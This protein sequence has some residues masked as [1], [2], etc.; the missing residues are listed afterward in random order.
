MAALSTLR[1]SLQNSLGFGTVSAAQANKLDRCINS[2]ILQVVKESPDDSFLDEVINTSILQVVNDSPDDSFLDEIINSAVLQLVNESPDDSFLD[3][4]INT[5]ILQTVN[6]SPNDSQLDEVINSAILQVVNESPDDSFLDEVINS[7]ILQTVNESP[8]D[9]YLDEI[10]N[11]AV[12]QV[13]NESPDDSYLDEIINSAVLQLVNE[14]PDDSYLD[15]IINTSILQTVNESP[16]DSYLDEIIN[17]AVLQLVNES[18]DD[19]YLDEIINTAI[20][21]VVNESLDNDTLDEALNAGLARAYSDGIPGIERDVFMGETSADTTMRLDNGVDGTTDNQIGDTSIA[22]DNGSGVGVLITG[23]VALQD[24]LEITSG[25]DEGK[26]W[27]IRDVTSAFVADIGAPLVTALEDNATVT[28]TRRSIQLPSAG[29]VVAVKLVD[30]QNLSYYPQGAANN[31]MDPFETGDPVCYEQRYSK[32]Q[33]KSYLI[34]YPAP[35][36][37]TKV[38]I[39]QN[40]DYTVDQGI[41]APEEAIDA[42]VERALHVYHTWAGDVDPVQ[43]S[44]SQEAIRDVD[45]QL[46]DTS[47]AVKIFVRS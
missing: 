14:S 3:E 12:L 22:T 47:S 24:I 42:V 33:S 16:D 10:I 18:P 37:T 39:I 30:G 45:N 13:V 44:L 34:L 32:R 28:V 21:Q 11:S 2:A 20:L 38:V 36:A 15:E 4:I 8:D 26:K 41:T 25:T 1:S 40:R 23:R 35:T 19:S 31:F 29:S 27:L 17:S 43:A 6:E 7:A 9:S 46:R 5:S